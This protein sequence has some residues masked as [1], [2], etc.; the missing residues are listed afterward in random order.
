[1]FEDGT[2][3]M[4]VHHG[5]TQEYLGMSLDFNHANQCRAT[6]IDYVDE[7]VF[8]YDKAL[9][10]LSDGFTTVKMKKTHQ[11]LVK[12]LMIYLL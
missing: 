6:M 12:L 9:T 3:Q 7:I 5:K 1:M 2:G 10:E 11:G 8:A 4:K